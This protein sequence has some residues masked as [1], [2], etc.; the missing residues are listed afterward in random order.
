MSVVYIPFLEFLK[1]AKIKKQVEEIATTCYFEEMRC[2]SNITCTVVLFYDQENLP[3]DLNL[4]FLDLFAESIRGV[5]KL[6][7]HTQ[8]SNHYQL[9]DLCVHSSHRRK[10]LSKIMIKDILEKADADVYLGI[11]FKNSFFDTV[12]KLYTG[13]GF[14]E[15]NVNRFSPSGVDVGREVLWLRFKQG[16]TKVVDQ[17]AYAI[18]ANLRK[19]VISTKCKFFFLIEYQTVLE[20]FNSF[21]DQS[22]EFSGNFAITHFLRNPKDSS[23]SQLYANLAFEPSTLVEG[24]DF[25]RFEV[26]LHAPTAPFSWHTHP[27][28][29]YMY[30]GC[31]IGWPSDQD[32]TLLVAHLDIRMHFVI[33][34][35]GVWGFSLN[36]EVRKHLQTLD[37]SHLGILAGAIKDAFHGSL[38]N[39]L[40]TN[41]IVQPDMVQIA[42]NDFLTAANGIS[43]NQLIAFNHLDSSVSAVYG[44]I[45]E[46]KLIDFHFQSWAELASQGGLLGQVHGLDCALL[47]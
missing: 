3:K 5:A 9:Y 13:V 4:H 34:E 30:H 12:L 35:E 42:K 10:G 24:Y 38:S 20:I 36:P 47:V 14:K 1:W 33:S 43:I 46:T 18:A 29:C 8:P 16:E 44:P 21:R 45:L 26:P 23:D 6:E 22:K 19:E 31:F 27:K 32:V 28:I 39:R 41:A 40:S 7:S 11:D 17:N 37:P 2:P 25:P 15:P